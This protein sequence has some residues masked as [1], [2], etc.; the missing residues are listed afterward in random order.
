M[1]RAVRFVFVFLIVATLV[2]AAAMV[3]LYVM[4]GSEPA[5]PARA[6]LVLSPTGDLPEVLPEVVF[7]GGELTVRGYVELIR[8]AKSDTR[9]TGILLRPGSLNSPFWAKIQEVRD[10]LDDFRASGK[11]V[12]AWLEY[13]GDREYYLATAADRVYLLP[14]ATLDLTGIASYELFLRGTFDWIGTFPDFLHVGDY[15]SAV[16]TYME[17][18]FTPAHREM[19]DSLNRS[20][21]EQLVR[22]IAD[23][24][25]KSEDEVRALIDDGPF[26]PVDAL[27]VGLIDEVA[28]ED[29]LDDINDD[30]RGAEFVDAEDY[31]QV[32]WSTGVTRRSKVAVINAVGV[33]NSG[34]SGFDPVNGAVVGADSLVEYIREARAD[35]SVRAI[36]LRVDSPG[37]SSTASDVIWRELSISRENSR[38]LIVS[39]SDL[40]ASGGYYIALAGDAIVAQPGTLTGSIGVYTG[41]FVT[42]G[43][44]EKLGANIES[45]SRG[46]QA[47][48]YS[49]DR[50]F[51]D[52]ERKKISESMQSVYD[53]FV[54]RTAAA[55]H[56]PPEKVDEVAQGRVWTGEQARQLGLVDELGGLYTAIGLAKQRAR[57]PADEEVEL[58][59]YPPRR[60][61]YEVL[62]DELQSP[63]GR[64]E[65]RYTADALLQLLGPRERKALAALLAPSRL[66]RSGQVLAH[67]PYVF[68]R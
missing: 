56:M 26:L 61:V 36:V 43:S 22:G 63:L 15:K 51:T 11:Y 17:R 25:K 8:K 52:D 59:V 65:E 19:A 5:V 48:M 10:A 62:A 23:A 66:F 34:R 53:Q 49:P 40:A 28:Y 2:S 50:R 12:H 13:A 4:V 57:I 30:L 38:P 33:I 45:I 54:E 3:M 9:I 44:F 27:R 6:T 39:M 21:F 41:K 31:A 18:S 68:V 37:G 60:S 1:K 67:M 14:S 24:R 47:E 7:G 29:E 55:R 64:I 20:Q 58:V 32:S 42:A 35:Q 16:N 46:K